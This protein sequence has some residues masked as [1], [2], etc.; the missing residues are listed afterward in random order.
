MGE[1]AREFVGLPSP[2]VGRAGAGGHPCQGI[3]HRPAGVAAP[4]TAFIATHYNVDFSEHYLASFLAERGYGFLGWNTRFRGNEAHFLLDHALAEIGVGVRWLREHS[5]VERVILLGNS[6]GGSLMAAYQ[7][8][9]SEPNIIP[10]AGMRRIPAIEQLPAGNLFITLAAHSGRPEVLTNWLDPSVTD[11]TDPLSADPALDPFNHGNGPPFSEEFQ[12]TYRDAQRARNE[13]ITDWALA[14]LAALEGTRARDR[15]FN[16]YRTW[17][18]LRMIDPAIEPS[19]RR[20][21]W[22][23]LGEPVKA[24]YGVFGIGSLC[25]L[26]SWLSMWSLRTSQCTAVPHLRRIT[27]PSLV[28]HATAD[29]GVFES[30]ARALFDAL[31]AADKRLELV[32]A[33]HYLLE[34]AGARTQAADLIAAWVKDHS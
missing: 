21:N 6:G 17:A 33:D 13:R 9:A 25:T 7:S 27:V 1:I 16:V 29:T 2:V 18:D 26:R 15:L 28:V 22:C 8:Q 11:E 34:P 20:P 3:Y 10:A 32:T 12:R 30:D 5:G 19:D 4:R 31:G 14:Q 23:Y 24:N